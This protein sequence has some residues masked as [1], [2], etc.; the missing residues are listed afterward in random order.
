MTKLWKFDRILDTF[1]ISQ[2][3]LCQIWGLVF[4][5]KTAF[6]NLYWT[7]S[8]AQIFDDKN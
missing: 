5:Q 7:S 4:K 1:D 8:L 3:I 6:V 2:K